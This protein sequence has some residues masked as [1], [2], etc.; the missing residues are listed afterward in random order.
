[1]GGVFGSLLSAI[2]ASGGC[3]TPG[4]VGG[5]RDVS[6]TCP[7]GGADPSV[8]GFLAGGAALPPG[9]AY[10]SIVSSWT[11]SGWNQTRL[12]RGG[13]RPDDCL[14]AAWDGLTPAASAEV[15]AAG[16]LSSPARSVPSDRFYASQGGDLAAIFCALNADCVILR[17]TAGTGLRVTGPD[18]RSVSGTLAEIPGASFISPGGDSAAI[19]L[20]FVSAG[21]YAVRL[22]GA[23]SDAVLEVTSGGQTS[24]LAG[25]V[26]GGGLTFTVTVP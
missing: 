12:P 2:G 8:S 10:T 3:L 16:L 6:F 21:E 15:N 23:A 9:V 17:T 18:G 1:M 19:I 7:T 13:A 24:V 25:V 5:V 20:P 14:G 22:E 4:T 11:P 26:E